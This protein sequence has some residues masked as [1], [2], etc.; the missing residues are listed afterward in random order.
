MVKAHHRKVKP[1][2]FGRTRTRVKIWYTAHSVAWSRH[3]RASAQA[4]WL[5]Q[6]LHFSLLLRHVRHPAV[7]RRPLPREGLG[8]L[9]LGGDGVPEVF[10]CIDSGGH[11]PPR[12]EA[13]T[14]VTIAGRECSRTKIPRSECTDSR[15]RCAYEQALLRSGWKG[16]KKVPRGEDPSFRASPARPAFRLQR[17]F[18]TTPSG[19]GVHA[20]PSDAPFVLDTF[21][22]V[23]AAFPWDKVDSRHS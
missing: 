15:P 10:D 2:D 17:R 20:E 6:H 3:L 4:S 16:R 21:L 9:R 14:S 5:A 13:R 11:G 22:L 7:V 8:F 1:A 12:I 19:S 23:V 18:P